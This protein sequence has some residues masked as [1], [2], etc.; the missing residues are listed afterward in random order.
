MASA[1]KG[2]SSTTSTRTYSIL[3]AGAYR[4]GM[5]NAIRAGDSEPR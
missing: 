4:R 3:G 2:S 1:M 5:E